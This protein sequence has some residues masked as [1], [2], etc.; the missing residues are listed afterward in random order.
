MNITILIIIANCLISAFVFQKPELIGRFS[1]NPYQIRTNNQYYR[2]ITS[3]FIHGD[4]YHLIFNMVS[5]YSFGIALAYY[6]TDLFGIYGNFMF[7]LLYM[8][9]LVLSD[10]QSFF[11][12]PN[13]KNYNSIGASG[14]VSSVIYA[15]IILNPL[16]GI[17]IFMIPIDIPGFIFGGIYLVYCQYQAKQMTDNTNHNAHFWGALVGVAFITFSYPLGLLYFFQTIIGWRPF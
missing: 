11:K 4:W 6:F 10:L 14:A 5:F 1:F 13:A 7:L 16:A 9:G 12:Y 2:F 15:C 8:L 3:G 17:R